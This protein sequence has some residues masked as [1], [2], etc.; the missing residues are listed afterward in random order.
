MVGIDAGLGDDQYDLQGSD[1]L[2]LADRQAWSLFLEE[3]GRDRYRVPRGMGTVF[4]GSLS[5]FFDLEGEDD[6]ALVPPS[7]LGR[8]E[9]RQ[10]LVDP[11]GALFQDR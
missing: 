10:T 5:G 9:N 3:A 4:N 1:G 11:A 7:G 8:R 2:G 6:Y